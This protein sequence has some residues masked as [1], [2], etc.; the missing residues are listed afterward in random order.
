MSIVQHGKAMHNTERLS[1]SKFRKT[2]SFP[3]A[4]RVVK[5]E[6]QEFQEWGMN[7]D[8]V[9]ETDKF[10]HPIINVYCEFS[11]LV[12]QPEAPAGSFLFF[13]KRELGGMPRS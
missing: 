4:E 13:K 11:I 7:N 10:C 12:T 2:K 5:E 6:P 8:D 1:C 3:C 9:P